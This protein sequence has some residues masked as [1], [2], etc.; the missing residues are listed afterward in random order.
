MDVPE[1]FI[2]FLNLVLTV[3]RI[4][5]PLP[6]GGFRAMRRVISVD[7]VSAVNQ[8]FNIFKWNP[9]TDAQKVAQLRDSPQ[10]T[11]LARDLGLSL[12]EVIDELNRRAVLIGWLQE[13]SV[14]NFRQLSAALEDYLTHP[15]EVIA[16]ASRDLGVRDF[17]E[18]APME[19]FRL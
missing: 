3:R 1:S 7:E 10:L 6:G 12:A 4:A 13:R 19:G 17:L 2:P 15:K 14:R 18:A 8:Y 16:K 9:A 11:K 5:V